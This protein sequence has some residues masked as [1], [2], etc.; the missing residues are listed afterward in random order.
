MNE[1]SDVGL[2]QTHRLQILLL[3]KA[4]P[5]QRSEGGV[6]LLRRQHLVIQT[7]AAKKKVPTQLK[8]PRH[9]F[10]ESCG[11][12]MALSCASASSAETAGTWCA[13]HQAPGVP[14]VRSQLPSLHCL[15]YVISFFFFL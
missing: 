12:S 5:L 14:R 9:D 7:E 1:K 11:C 6:S 2:S 13:G 10:T 8:S 3:P 15:L 4:E